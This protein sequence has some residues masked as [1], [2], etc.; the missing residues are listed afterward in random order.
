MRFFIL[1]A[2]FTLIT[3]EGLEEDAFKCSCQATCLAA[4]DPYIVNNYGMSSRWDSSMGLSLFQ[5]NT[6][7]SLGDLTFEVQAS[8][9][10]DFITA[11]NSSGWFY[12]VNNCTRESRRANN[13]AE[14]SFENI[15]STITT[16][17]E[18]MWRSGQFALDLYVRYFAVFP[19]RYS[20]VSWDEYLAKISYDGLCFFNE[21]NSKPALPGTWHSKPQCSCT[22]TAFP[23][24]APTS[25]P[26][27]SLS[28]T[29]TPTSTP[30]ISLSPTETP[31][32]TP[33][34][35]QSPTTEDQTSAPSES[36]SPTSKAPSTP[37]ESQSPTTEN[38]TSAP[39]GSQS[40]TTEDQTSA[41]SVSPNAP[42]SS[43][44]ESP[45]TSEAP[46]SSPSIDSVKELNPELNPEQPGTSTPSSASMVSVSVLLGTIIYNLI[47]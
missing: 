14:D 13:T 4:G 37:S 36:K 22:G 6:L 10:K 30:S 29:E 34:G 20:N 26:S 2:V 44:A 32:S 8:G 21:T 25:S 1:S 11:V 41:P 39:S 24:E 43:P 19:W 33:S 47:I 12:S 7:P 31:T 27:I 28:P 35:S 5:T 45:T 40:P 17:A 15:D 18:C 38:Q 9:K 42:Q 23:T 46:S 16:T 3:V